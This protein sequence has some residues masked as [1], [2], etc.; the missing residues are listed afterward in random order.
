MNLQGDLRYVH[1]KY[2]K[3]AELLDMSL[4]NLYSRNSELG[5]WLRAKNI[6][7]KIG[8]CLFVHA[9]ISK[10]VNDLNLTPDEINGVARI[11][12]DRDV[13]NAEQLVKSL[14]S[15]NGP[16]WYRGYY[17]ENN[18]LDVINQTLKQYGVSR[19]V[20]GHTVVA[21]TISMWHDSKVINIDTRH[22]EGKSE[23]LLIESGTYYRLSM[24]GSKT[25][26]LFDQNQNLTDFHNGE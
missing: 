1:S 10:A 21:D 13:H 9:G 24:D 15:Q 2:K 14:M 5:Q 3:S 20:T 8:D 6:V 17:S 26:I 7:E 19:I 22:K 4:V 11:Y 12:Y 25:K 18:V 16:I 23:A